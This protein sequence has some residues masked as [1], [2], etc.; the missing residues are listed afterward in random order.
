MKYKAGDKVRIRRDLKEGNDFGLYVNDEM[1]KLAGNIIKIR[2]AYD[3]SY[4]FRGSCY[5]WTDDMFVNIVM[6]KAELMDMPL[7][8]KIITNSGTALIKT[9]TDIF[10]SEEGLCLCDYGINDDLTITYSKFG[11]RIVKIKEPVYSTIYEYVEEEAK[12][13]TVA[14]IEK[15]VGHKVKIIKEEKQ[16]GRYGKVCKSN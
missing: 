14:E 6:T 11:T 10:E 3:D 15:L 2:E 9:D 4:R 8:T 12:E 13:M 7:G 5:A 16:N 1:E